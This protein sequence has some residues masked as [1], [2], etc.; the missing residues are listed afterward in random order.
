MEWKKLLAYAIESD[1]VD[2]VKFW[3]YLPKQAVEELINMGFI[4]A[5]DSL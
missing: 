5:I 1:N 4:S 3:I 2:A